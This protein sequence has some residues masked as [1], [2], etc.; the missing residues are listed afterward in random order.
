M[1]F[2]TLR[3]LIDQAATKVGALAAGQTL[4][5]E[6]LD[7]FNTFATSLF[8]QLAEDEIWFISNKDELPASLCPYLA[9]L[10]AN[11]AGPDYGVPFSTDAKAANEAI[12]RRLVR[13]KD[14]SEPQTVNYY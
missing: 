5:V 6:D 7:A 13:S 1:A 3:Q 10:L 9:S 8:D 4:Q 11:L 14:A 2:F 12:L